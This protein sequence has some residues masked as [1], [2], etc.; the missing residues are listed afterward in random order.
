MEKRSVFKQEEGQYRHLL[1]GSLVKNKL[2][3]HFY[4]S[5]RQQRLRDKPKNEISTGKAILEREK[6]H[7]PLKC[8]C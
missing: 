7:T 4:L 8:Y 1:H 3:D 2:G 5:N 6:Y